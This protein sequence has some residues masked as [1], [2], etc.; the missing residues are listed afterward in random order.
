[1]LTIVTL[2]NLQEVNPEWMQ[3][4]PS[5]HPRRHNANPPVQL[6][7]RLSTATSERASERGADRE[8]QLDVE[9]R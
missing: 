7:D 9:N 5:V 3:A 8:R 1:M 4:V 2:L 6:V